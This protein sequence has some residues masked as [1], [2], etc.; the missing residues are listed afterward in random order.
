MSLLEEPTDAWTV[1][2]LIT[3]YK[4]LTQENANTVIAECNV[5]FSTASPVA[6]DTTVSIWI[7][8]IWTGK[9]EVA[10]VHAIKAYTDED[11]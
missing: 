11:L 5:T 3:E 10:P 7:M 4:F 6:N 8:S 9:A 2:I 1:H